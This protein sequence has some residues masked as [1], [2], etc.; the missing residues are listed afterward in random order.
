MNCEN[1]GEPLKKGHALCSS[2]GELV[3]RADIPRVAPKRSKK[4][5]IWISLA[6]VLVV[7]VGVVGYFL[8]PVLTEAVLIQ[9]DPAYVSGTPVSVEGPSPREA[10]TTFLTY[11]QQ[12]EYTEAHGLLLGDLPIFL[13][14]IEEEYS[15]IFQKLSFRDIS[16]TISGSQASVTL[17]ISAVDFAAVM[18]EVMAEAE[19]FLEIFQETTFDELL[20]QIDLMLMEKMTS[21]T[22]PM[23]NNEITIAL[24][25]SEDQWKIVADGNLADA[26]TGGM[27]SFVE[28]VDELH[29]Y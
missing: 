18:G 19:A 23:V 10:V 21:D 25:I 24:Q 2:C 6:I 3:N 26:V 14:E 29:L 16:E 13:Y 28:T 15:G 20:E 17:T 1:C 8:G 12:G 7:T 11:I 27:L 9:H 22:A 4:I 5:L